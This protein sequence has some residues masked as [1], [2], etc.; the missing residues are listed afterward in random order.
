MRFV[1]HLAN[2]IFAKDYI[3]AAGGAPDVSTIASSLAKLRRPDLMRM[4]MDQMNEQIY[5][6]CWPKKTSQAMANTAW[7]CAKRQC[8]AR[9]VGTH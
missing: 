9:A 5:T 6:S 8:V 7:A 1:N 4:F 2:V 3:M